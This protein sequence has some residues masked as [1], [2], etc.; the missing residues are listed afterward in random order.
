L[1]LIPKLK[2]FAA[3]VACKAA[4]EPGVTLSAMITDN[5]WS[6]TVAERLGP[7]EA[8]NL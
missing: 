5:P 3:A 8:E 4:I 2:T 1:A 6:F 7:R